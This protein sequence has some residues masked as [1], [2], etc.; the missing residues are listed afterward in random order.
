MTDVDLE[1][2][3]AQLYEGKAEMEEL[4]GDVHVAQFEKVKAAKVQSAEEVLERAT[5]DPKVQKTLKKTP[6]GKAKGRGRGRGVP[7]KGNESS[8]DADAPQDLETEKD[9]GK[10]AKS[11]KDIQALWAEKDTS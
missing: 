3:A 6:G 10:G 4:P 7:A 5:A 9:N 2:Q 11:G 8:P 1:A